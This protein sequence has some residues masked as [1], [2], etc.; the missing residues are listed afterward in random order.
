MVR[1]LPSV[2]ACQSSPEATGYRKDVC[3]IDFAI[4]MKRESG[5]EI[6]CFVP[7][8]DDYGVKFRWRSAVNAYAAP[9]AAP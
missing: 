2:S 6:V 5:L 7:I 8:L 4:R 3:E 1:H 9:V